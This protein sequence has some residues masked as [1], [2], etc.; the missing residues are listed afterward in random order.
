[1]PFGFEVSGG[2][3]GL[4]L[5]SK[6]IGQLRNASHGRFQDQLALI[7]TWSFEIWDVMLFFSMFR[8]VLYV[9]DGASG[10][11]DWKINV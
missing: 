6:T 8:I 10:V 4:W 9:L 5:G 1:M 3:N 11:G 2:R 7:M